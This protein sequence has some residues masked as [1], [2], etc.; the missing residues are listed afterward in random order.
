V[1]VM[2]ILLVRFSQF[3]RGPYTSN[4][5]KVRTLSL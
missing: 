4:L 5:C 1:S 3:D 2:R